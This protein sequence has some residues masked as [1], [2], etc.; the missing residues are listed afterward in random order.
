MG[1][2]DVKDEILGD[3][4]KE[5]ERIVKEA[6][7]RKQEIIS[8]AEE[9][10]EKIKQ[11]TE[12]E[13]EEKKERIRKKEISGARMK[14]RKEKMGAKQESLERAFENFR[15]EIESLDGEQ[16]ESFV[17]SCVDLADFPIGKAI[18]TQDFQE[19]IEEEGIEYEEGQEEGVILVSSDGE[20][21]QSFTFENIVESFR[22]EYRKDVA[23]ELL[24]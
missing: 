19:A 11:E 18:A 4:E 22:N 21:R 17:K 6:K 1:I 2:E 5:S 14:A 20:R 12:E 16:K 13:I 8:E 23:E 10:A 15:D 9:K 24:G 7:E 3:A